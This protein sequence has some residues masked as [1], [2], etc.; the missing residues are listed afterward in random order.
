MFNLDGIPIM[1]Y[2]VHNP[3][4]VSLYSY[5]CSKMRKYAV[6]IIKDL[7]NANLEMLRIHSKKHEYLICFEEDT[8]VLAI[9]KQPNEN[10]QSKEDA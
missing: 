3:S 4:L 1:N 9:F 8:I 2:N 5:M 7:A 10:A 6:D